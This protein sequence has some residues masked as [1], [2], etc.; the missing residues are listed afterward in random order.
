MRGDHVGSIKLKMLVY[1][2]IYMY[3]SPTNYGSMYV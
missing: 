1:D 2:S 3:K